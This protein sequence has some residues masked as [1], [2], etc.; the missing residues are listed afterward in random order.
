MNKS[1]S[2]VRFLYGT[3]LGR[4]LLKLLLQVHADRLMVRFLWSP[5]SRPVIGWY[6]SRHGIFLT[7]TQ[8]A[9]FGSF[10]DFF[11]RTRPE[12]EIDTTP[13]HLISPCDGWLSA[14][15]INKNSSFAIKGSWYR[16]EDLLQDQELAEQYQ[17]GDCLIFRL[18]ASHYHH[19]CYI[20]DGYQGVNHYIPGLLHSIQPIACE[21]YP[22]YTLNRRCWT[23]MITE[24]FGPVVQAEVGALVVGGIFNERQ[25]TRFLK[26]MEKGH[27]ELAGSTIVL[28]FQKSHI[29]LHASLRE[30]LADGREFRVEQGM[31]IG[32][33]LPYLVGAGN[34]R[35]KSI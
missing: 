22:V 7:E 35:T 31:W 2:I 1:S 19:Y 14:Y 23:L 17:D 3:A 27:F 6:A 30:Y 18:C 29:R 21:T 32:D 33:A 20:D 24:H 25:N 26:G 9:S 11:A 15:T 5:C 28:L 16:L 12:I 8:K 10:R 34:E 4:F 13:G